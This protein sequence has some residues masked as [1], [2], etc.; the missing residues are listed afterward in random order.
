[1]RKTAFIPGWA[2]F[3]DVKNHLAKPVFTFN[4]TKICGAYNF[5][6]FRQ[7]LVRGKAS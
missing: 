2:I 1:M 3:L 5:S 6:S 7:P 4:A